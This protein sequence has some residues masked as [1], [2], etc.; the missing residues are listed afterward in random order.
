MSCSSSRTTP[1]LTPRLLA[2]AAT[3]GLLSLLSGCMTEPAE[4]DLPWNKPQ[5]WEGTPAIPPGVFH[6]D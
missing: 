6:Q 5:T 2:L 4:N 3:A 1:P